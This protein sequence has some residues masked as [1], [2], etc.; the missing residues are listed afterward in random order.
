MR[1]RLQSIIC[2][3]LIVACTHLPG[4][5]RAGDEQDQMAR[6][7]HPN[8]LFSADRLT[9]QLVSGVLFSPVGIGPENPT[10]N[11]AQTNLRLGWMLNSPS[12]D[13][14]V[15]RGNYEAILEVSN[16]IVLDGFGNYIGGV[17]GLIRRNFVQKDA[18]I[19]P[20]FQI[21]VGVVYT[22]AYE[23]KSQ[24]AIGQAIEFTPQLSIG[25]RYLLA[26]N[27]SFDVE[28]MFHHISNASLADRNDGINALGG[29]LGVTYFLKSR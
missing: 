28:G 16:S 8:G 22:D 17:T 1:N 19:V 5:A 24:Q 21:G 4:M 29:F 2:L 3:C 15:L 9:F 6:S 25:M 10:F 27:W 12:A 7:S 23:D 26:T 14:S 20:Y 11:Y 18:K 13:T